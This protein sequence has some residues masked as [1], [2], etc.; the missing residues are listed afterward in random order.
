MIQFQEVSFA[1]S[2]RSTLFEGLTLDFKPGHIYGL[3]GKNGSGKTSLLKLITGLSRPST[4][5][6]KVMQTPPGKRPYATL[7]EIYYIPE[8][9]YF[10]N[11]S[12]AHYKKLY[13]PFYPKF[14]GAQ[15]YAY[16]N[17]LEL[18]SKDQLKQLS[19]GQRKKAL[20][21]FGLAT[22]TRL[23]ILDEPTNG[24]DIPSKKQLRRLLSTSINEDR[25]FIIST[26]QV[27]DL[28]NLIDHIIILEKGEILLAHDVNTIVDKLQFEILHQEPHDPKV[29][30]T[31]RVAGGYLSIRPNDGKPSIDIDVEVLFNA[32]I[33]H[34]LSFKKHLN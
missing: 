20:I 30:Y 10:P 3:L 18:C 26:H 16:L 8:E 11:L 15:F 22:N 17:A 1:Y 13:A 33:D 29:I 27:R 5:D 7:S 28:Q 21:A 6:L 23:L 2:R 31:E 19:L 25:L 14:D 24:L 4:G 12:I 34:G 9:L 32:V